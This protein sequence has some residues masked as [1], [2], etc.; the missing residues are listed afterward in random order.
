MKTVLIFLVSITFTLNT[1]AQWLDMNTPASYHLYAIEAVT[2]NIIFAGGYGGS[3]V[4]TTDAGSNWEI[5][6]IGS[7]DWINS[8]HFHN[9]N[10]GWLA[11]SSGNSST[12]NIYKTS[13]GGAT[14]TSERN[15][16]EYSS[17]SWPTEQVGYFGT[18]NGTIIK[19]I[20]S[21][22]SWTV[23]NLPT[24]ENINDLQF[25][26]AQT[27]FAT[28][29]DY[30]LYRTIDGGNSWEAIYQPMIRRI[31]FKDASNGYCVTNSGEIG[32]TTDGGLTF[33]FW[34]STFI[35]YKLSD[36]FFSSP[37]IG[38]V[39]GGLDCSNGSCITKPVILKTIDG[40]ANWINDENHPM[41]G[42]ERGFYQIDC[43]PSGI[44]F[45]SGSDALVYKNS[46]VGL[47]TSNIL[48]DQT[49]I[50]PNPNNGNFSVIIEHNV[51]T[52]GIYSSSGQLII[53]RLVNEPGTQ[54]F[55]LNS[56]ESGI[57]FLHEKLKNGQLKRS[58]LIIE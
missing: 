27:G 30:Y 35:N 42:L 13:N 11:T 4:K 41:V 2:D 16:E 45:I 58:K 51:E 25:I 29:T 55:D 32:I 34:Q 44:P 50:F 5:V 43:T 47:G 6:P 31:Y 39:V 15:L 19:T 57:Y 33:N 37:M 24:T 46:S 48:E 3:L 10:N 49:S 26:D 52:I 53:E 40:G 56:I 22:Q 7:N 14:W 17:M 8:I 23:I 20:D 28:S 21:G 38:Y 12:G 9:E 36:V 54:N 1:H 18:W